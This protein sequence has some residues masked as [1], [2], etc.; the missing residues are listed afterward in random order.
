MH[1]FLFL[2]LLFLSGCSLFY[3]TPKVEKRKPIYELSALP[4]DEEYFHSPTGDIAGRIPRGWLQVN[5][6][7]IPE[8]ENI[9]SVYT[10][11]ERSRAMVLIEIP[12]TADLRRKV[13]RDGILALAEVSF[14]SKLLK[15]QGLTMTRQP[16]V[17][18]VDSMLF[19]N[20]E[21]SQVIGNAGISHNRV[22]AFSAGVRFYELSI[23]ELRP[24]NDSNQYLENFRILQSVIAGLEGVAAVRGG[25]TTR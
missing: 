24:S 18:T 20:Y 25:N 3:S 21:Y 15:R 16:E 11:K 6:E 2:T 19:V 17:F 10:D 13:E 12:G 22:V 7:S 4:L 9:L 1:R 14:Q 23:I 8:L 5:T